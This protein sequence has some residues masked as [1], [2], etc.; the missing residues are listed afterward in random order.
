MEFHPRLVPYKFRPPLRS[1]WL[2]PLVALLSDAFYLKRK[3]AISEIVVDGVEH[4]TNAV[5]RGDAIMLAGNHA[6]HADPYVLWKTARNHGWDPRFLAAREGFELSSHA[7]IALQYAGAFSIDRDG[8]DLSA[9]KTAIETLASCRHPL[10][11]FPEGEIYHHQ[12][13]LDP[14]HDG[15][16]SILLK[17]MARVPPGRSTLL[18]P[19][20]L[21]YRHPP[22]VEKTWNDRIGRLEFATRGQTFPRLPPVDRL[23]ALGESELERHE[24]RYLGRACPGDHLPERIAHLRNTILEQVETR[25]GVS[26]AAK[27]TPERFRA[28]RGHIRRRL[29]ASDP[30]PDAATSAALKAEFHPLHHVHQLYSYPGTYLLAHPS[31]DRI[32][33]TI[34]KLEEDILDSPRYPVARTAVVRFAKPMDAAAMLAKHS[35]Q[36]KPAAAELSQSLTTALNHLLSAT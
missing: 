11:I 22:E 13:E 26:H 30:A 17:G 14:I 28:L 34:L 4:V 33:E 31:R 6:D 18:F 32:T 3:F 25:L 35:G 24:A 8:P 19:F 21:H 36:A 7:S 29:L 16:A 20:A 9:L 2:T 15:F 27:P 5:R 10:V 12:E 1:W 23:L